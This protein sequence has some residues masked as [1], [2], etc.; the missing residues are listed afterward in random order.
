[1]TTCKETIVVIGHGKYDYTYDTEV[2]QSE[3]P[4]FEATLFLTL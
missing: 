1:M 2:N 4:I 3:L